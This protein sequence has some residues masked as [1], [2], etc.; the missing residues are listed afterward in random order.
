MMT[1]SDGMAEG[2]ADRRRSACHRCGWTLPLVKITRARRAKLG[3]ATAYHWL[4]DQCI[5]DLTLSASSAEPVA[6]TT[7]ASRR[8][9]S[10]A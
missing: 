3:S 2:A 9:R 8:N 4:C 7:V 1:T 5:A 10:V 6:S